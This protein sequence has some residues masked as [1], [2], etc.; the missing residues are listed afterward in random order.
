[1]QSHWVTPLH[2]DMHHASIGASP[3]LR[4][5]PL[6][7]PSHQVLKGLLPNTCMLRNP[8]CT[9]LGTYH[10]VLRS[11]GGIHVLLFRC[12]HPLGMVLDPRIRAILGPQT[13]IPGTPEVQNSPFMPFL[14]PHFGGQSGIFAARITD[15]DLQKGPILGF[16]DSIS[17]VRAREEYI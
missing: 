16:K 8:H 2:G 7:L 6:Y 17:L 4:V 11:D 1:M 3:G 14:D 10:V 5:Y 13:W 15:L 12:L 9:S